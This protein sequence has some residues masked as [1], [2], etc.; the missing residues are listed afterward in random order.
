MKSGTCAGLDPV[1]LAH[2]GRAD[3]GELA[4]ALHGLEH[5]HALRDELEGV[6]VGGRHRPPGPVQRARRR[7][8]EVVGLV[9]RRLRGDEPERLDERREQQRAARR[10]RPRTPGPTGTRA[11]P[12]CGRSGRRACPS[13]RAPTRGLL[14]LP[15]PQ[16]EVAEADER[17]RR[18]A[19][20]A[21]DRFGQRVVGAMGERI[22][23]DCEQKT[24]LVKDLSSSAEYRLPRHRGYRGPLTDGRNHKT[25]PKKGSTGRRLVIV[26]SPAKAKTIAGLPRQGLHGRVVD[27][28]RPRPAPQRRRGSGR[29][30]AGAVG[31]PRR[32]RRPRLRAA[33]RGRPEE[34]VGRQRP[35]RQAQARPTSSCSRQTKTAKARRS[36]GIS[37]QVL[38]P[39]VPGAP[40]GLPRDHEGRRSS[41]RSARPA[42][43]TTGSST[44]RRHA[45]SSTGST[46]TRSRPS[47]GGR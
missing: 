10:S 33:L 40:D 4:H 41:A 21:A 38:K 31:A 6:A 30:E 27:R 34:E 16:E 9:P 5:G 3:P 13:R 17:V 23:V 24:G 42:R 15:Q 14:G 12:R 36:P 46:A 45:G 29:A 26:E 7:S 11:A 20:G 35:A 18:P 39:K 19:A 22:A 32:Q 37:S 44:R 47:S 25:R 2:L 8:E 43:S 28:P 1:A